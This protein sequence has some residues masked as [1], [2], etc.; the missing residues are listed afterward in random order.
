MQPW[1][2][3]RPAGRPG[4]V[5]PSGGQRDE[6]HVTGSS[7]ASP[8]MKKMSSESEIGEKTILIDQSFRSF[9][10]LLLL[11]VSY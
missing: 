2:A 7:S 10:Y 6:Q 1:K 8:N 5:A 4:T 11:S 9:I 3:G